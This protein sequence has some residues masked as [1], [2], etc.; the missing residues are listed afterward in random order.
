MTAL[1]QLCGL[2]MQQP[3]GDFD[4]RDIGELRQQRLGHP[5]RL[6]GG[7]TDDRGKTG[8]SEDHSPVGTA[9]ASRG[10]EP[11]FSAGSGSTLVSNPIRTGKI[12]GANR[13]ETDLVSRH[14]TER[15]NRL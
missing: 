5:S 8:I 10:D 11:R 12:D 7:N 15:G 1:D 14:F 3:V 9:T 6:H 4:H 2:A 13:H